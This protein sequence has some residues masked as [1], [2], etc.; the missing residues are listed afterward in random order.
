MKYLSIII[1]FYSLNLQGQ[2]TRERVIV[3]DSY[4]D[5]I[6]V[7]KT[8]RNDSLTS[9][10]AIFTS[11]DARTSTMSQFETFYHGDAKEFYSWLVD[12][13]SLLKNEPGTM[14]ILHECDVYVKTYGGTKHLEVYK[15]EESYYASIT[16]KVL[17][18][19]M[20]NYY[21]WCVKNKLNL[22]D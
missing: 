10:D 12:L 2:V 15:K 20:S 21:N 7:V 1:L 17:K 19:M 4:P 3:F 9:I 5:L 14:K 11:R 8:Y 22:S 6:E 18:L 16:S 13:E